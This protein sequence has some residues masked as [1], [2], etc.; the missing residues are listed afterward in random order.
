MDKLANATVIPYSLMWIKVLRSDYFSFDYYAAINMISDFT[1]VLL[2][3][4]V[5]NILQKISYLNNKGGIYFAMAA[6]KFNKNPTK[7]IEYDINTK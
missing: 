4:M 1:G 3:G 2:C 5:N 6:L 7:K